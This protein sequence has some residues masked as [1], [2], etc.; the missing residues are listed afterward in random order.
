MRGCPLTDAERDGRSEDCWMTLREIAAELGV[1]NQ[2]VDQLVTAAIR[3]L[4]WP[5]ED[6]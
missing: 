4:R 2:R 3:K 5:P 1:S 6:R